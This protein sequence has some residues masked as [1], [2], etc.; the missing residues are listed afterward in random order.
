[1]RKMRDQVVVDSVREGKNGSFYAEFQ[2]MGGSISVA[3]D[4]Q[5]AEIV[6]PMIGQPAIAVFQMRPRSQVVFG[7]RS[8][9]MFEPVAFLEFE[10][11][12]P[13]FIPGQN[14]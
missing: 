11:K 7:D 8:V 9:T 13:G 1:M 10:R 14:K 5:T 2:I 12:Q 4:K 6:K 3:V